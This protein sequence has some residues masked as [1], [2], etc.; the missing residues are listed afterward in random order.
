MGPKSSVQTRFT[1]IVSNRRDIPLF[2]TGDYTLSHTTHSRWNSFSMCITLFGCM[3]E[4]HYVSARNDV[5]KVTACS[6]QVI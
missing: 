3:S 2:K 4:D 1:A 6:V 5:E